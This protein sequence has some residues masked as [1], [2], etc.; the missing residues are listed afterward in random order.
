[1]F[2]AKFS[3]YY[4]KSLFSCIKKWP[5]SII[6]QTQSTVF[7]IFHFFKSILDTIWKGF[8][9]VI[10]HPHLNYPAVNAWGKQTEYFLS[11]ERRPF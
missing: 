2:T 10:S 5:F 8:V 7:R 1:M 3:P 11:W 9:F 6:F 4:A